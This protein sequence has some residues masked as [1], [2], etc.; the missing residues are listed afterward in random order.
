MDLHGNH[1]RNVHINTS[2][3]PCKQLSHAPFAQTWILPSQMHT[4]IMA[5]CVE[6]YFFHIGSGIFWNWI[7]WTR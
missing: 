2:G 4:K 6:N 5:K 3:N 7:C 1:T